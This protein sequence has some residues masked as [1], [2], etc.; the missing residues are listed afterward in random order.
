MDHTDPPLLDDELAAF[1][2]REVSITVASCDDDRI[3][4]LARGTGCRISPDRRQLTV[5]L[6]APAAAEVLADVCSSGRVA[7]VFS[8]PATH[9]TLQLKGVDAVVVSAAPG[10]AEH[11]ARHADAFASGLELLGYSAAVIRSVLQA[12]PA[13]LVAIR[14][15]PS[16][17][18]LQTPGPE[19]GQALR[20]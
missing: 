12:A 5:L 14:F 6:A 7:V 8:L 20:A 16:F 17:G 18:S 10:D 3:P 9:R 2:C 11:A 4:H 19:A 13:E 1:V 15:T